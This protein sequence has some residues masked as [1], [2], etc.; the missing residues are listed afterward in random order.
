[1]VVTDARLHEK[2]QNK[3]KLLHK[4]LFL[5]Q[6]AQ[7]YRI[8]KNQLTASRP[9]PLQSECLSNC[10]SVPLGTPLHFGHHWSCFI[11]PL[12]CFYLQ[13]RLENGY[14]RQGG[15]GMEKKDPD[16]LGLK[17][18]KVDIITIYGIIYFYLSSL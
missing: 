1:M 3:V 18:Y 12:L 15:S 7:I 10:R 2:S 13:N 14:N 9:P 16:T 8:E 17:G 11:R 4:L 5:P 6:F